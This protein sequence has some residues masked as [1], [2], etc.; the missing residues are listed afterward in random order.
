MV[1]FI[2]CNWVSNAS[3]HLNMH[4]LNP[5][6]YILWHFQC[7]YIVMASNGYRSDTIL[8]ELILLRIYFILILE[9]K[10]SG[11]I[12]PE[13]GKWWMK[14]IGFT[15]FL[16]L[17]KDKGE[18]LTLTSNFDAEFQEFLKI[19]ATLNHKEEDR[20]ACKLEINRIMVCRNVL[21]SSLS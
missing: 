8:I 21:I 9:N 20:I 11:L 4:V 13:I 1:I 3:Y 7:C 15:K 17:H 16:K 2:L 5:I 18:I 12:N 19:S 10:S 14:L 6:W